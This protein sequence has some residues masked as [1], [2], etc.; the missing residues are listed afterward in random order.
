MLRP[1]EVIGMPYG[2]PDPSTGD[3][4]LFRWL[5][6]V[7]AIACAAALGR[8]RRVLAALAGVLF[9]VAAVGFWILTLGRPYGLLV[10]P[11][12]TRRAA[13]HA[14][15]AEAGRADEGFVTGEPRVGSWTD[16]VT[17]RLSREVLL[18][19]PTWLPVMVLPLTALALS[20][21]ARGEDA[22][23]AAL[24]WTLFSTGDLDTVRGTAFVP[25]LWARPVAALAFTLALVLL[26]LPSRALT[27]PRAGVVLGAL[28]SSIWIAFA[29]AGSGADPIGALLMLTFDQG[30]WFLLAGWTLWTTRGGPAMSLL[31]TGA[32]LAGAGAAGLGVDAWAAQ[33][34][35]R[36]GLL[37]AAIPAGRALAQSLATWVPSAGPVL[38]GLG[39]ATSTLAWWA[40][41]RWDLVARQSVEPL[42]D[43]VA[44]PIEWLRRE[45]PA[46]AVVLAA[47]NYAP[48]VAILGGRRVLRAPTLLTPADDDRRVRLERAV[49]T[50]GTPPSPALLERYGLRY[51]LA[52]PGDFQELGVG[53]PHELA[54][55][56]HL[57]L[58]HVS[59]EGFRVY[60]IV[61]YN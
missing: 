3:I 18:L 17:S 39:A 49:L 1:G 57:K 45:T 21:F 8:G 4:V 16:S 5:L 9:G 7:L 43:A 40:P 48:A 15:I 10:D 25:G 34:F 24:L 30:L 58:R 36:A 33:A 12:I 28:A 50:G 47:P 60:E 38:L 37:V 51:V 52:A 32:L 53:A 54:E 44:E 22:A 27:N 19:A 61:Q 31:A 56:P 59:P 55:R 46:G 13:E 42:S 14:V 11:D 2:V 29:P 20:R 35:Y 23:L 41:P 26:G 6:V